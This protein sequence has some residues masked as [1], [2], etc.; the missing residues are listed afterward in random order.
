MTAAL[1]SYSSYQKRVIKEIGLILGDRPYYFEKANNN[2]LKLLIKDV[3]KPLFTACTPSDAKSFDNFIAAVRRSIKPNQE[4]AA[5]DDDVPTR[6]HNEAIDEP[7]QALT[8]KIA[9]QLCKKLRHQLSGIVSKEEQLVANEGIEE[10]ANFRKTL[11]KQEI[12]SAIKQQKHPTYI[13]AGQMKW[14]QA[15][16]QQHL[17]FMLPCM[18]QYHQPSKLSLA[19]MM[20][21]QPT[22]KEPDLAAACRGQNAPAPDSPAIRAAKPLAAPDS[23]PEL[24]SQPS[25]K[26]L[27]SLKKLSKPML[28]TLMQDIEQALREKHLEDIEE[29]ISLM[30]AKGIQLDDIQQ[31]L[32]S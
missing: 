3:D 18:A 1:R 22:P 17:D 28:A 25:R 12:D 20:Q 2:H 14:L 19:P 24:M 31:R 9:R 21:A 10:V 4:S 23:L 27:Q 32:P 26:R 16:L 30:Q 5:N 6:S 11:L 8:K 29:V 13:P 15:E 7:S